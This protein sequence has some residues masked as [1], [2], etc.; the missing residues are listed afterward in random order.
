MK[1]SRIQFEIKVLDESAIEKSEVNESAEN[2]D[3]AT[4]STIQEG[5]EGKRLPRIN[6]QTDSLKGLP[7]PTPSPVIK[8]QPFQ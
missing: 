8:L 5:N 2:R 3:S 6:Q 7:S 1:I 4:S